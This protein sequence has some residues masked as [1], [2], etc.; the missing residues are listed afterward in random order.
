MGTLARMPLAGGAP[1]RI[2]EQVVDADWAPDGKNFA[3]IRHVE[4]A[5]VLEYP[6]G[7]RLY[8]SGGW[9]SH[10]RFSRDGTRLAFIEHPWFGDDAGR[11]VVIDLEGRIVMELAEP[12]GGTSGLTWSPDGSEVWIAVSHHSSGRDLFG[13]DMAGAS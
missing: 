5:F 6:I 13:I 4:S 11:P 7:R 2:C 3:I 12:F 10:V 1:R 8:A 9:L